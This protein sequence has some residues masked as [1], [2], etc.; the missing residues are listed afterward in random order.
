LIVHRDLKPSNILVTDEGTVK[1]LD[2]GIAKLLSDEGLDDSA[3]RTRTGHRIMTPEYATPEQIRGEPVTTATDVYQLGVLLYELLTGARPFR[4]ESRIREAVER[5]ILEEEP[6]LPSTLVREAGT[7]GG[8]ADTIGD[9]R[10]TRVDDLARTLSGDLDTISLM[11]LRKDPQQ[12][13]ASVEQFSEDIRRYLNGLP[14]SARSQGVRYRTGKFIARNRGRVLAV[15]AVFVLLVGASALYTVQVGAERDRAAQAL[16]QSESALAFLRD[17]IL[18]ADPVD[19]DPNLPIG[20]VLDSASVRVDR[21]LGA[22]PEVARTVHAALGSV[23][24]AMDNNEKAEFHLRRADVLRSAATSDVNVARNLTN[25]ATLYGTDGRIE[26]AD[27]VIDVAIRV[28]READ[29]PAADL[30]ASMD[31]YGTVLLNSGRDS[32]ALN[33]YEEALGLLRT[34]G[35]PDTALT[36]N[37]ISIAYHNTGDIERALASQRLAVEADRQQGSPPV[38]RGISLAVL[39]SL[40]GNAGMPDSAVVYHERA[41]ALIRGALGDRHIETITARVSLALQLYRNGDVD[42]AARISEDALADAKT[43]IDPHSPFMAYAQEVTGAILCDSGRPGEGAPLVRESLDTR[44]AI[45]PEGHVM[46]LN[47]KSL[48]GHCLTESGRMT[49]AESLLKEAYPGLLGDLGPEHPY[50]VRARGRLMRL[51]SL[52]DRSALTAEL[53]QSLDR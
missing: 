27:S 1:L 3:P 14:V 21:E 45:L 46:L 13:Y 53:E 51:Y 20:V 7:R 43:T 32:L 8:N 4:V 10:S 52:T 41:V 30:G 9:V 25:L 34:A 44:T 37:N 29:A 6:T 50:T 23:Y 15:A 5:A 17:M 2:F 33:V 11:A 49:E 19:S 48:L 38:R 28:L 31:A 18:E 36:L 22:D 26:E 16:R 39:A 35:S 40:Y 47:G 42:R 12:R 24:L